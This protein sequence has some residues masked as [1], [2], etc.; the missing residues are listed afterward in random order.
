MLHE[1]YEILRIEYIDIFC[2]SFSLE[3]VPFVFFIQI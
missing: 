1:F 2:Y 3:S